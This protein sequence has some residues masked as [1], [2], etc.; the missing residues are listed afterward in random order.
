MGWRNITSPAHA[1]PGRAEGGG[2][3]R[4]GQAQNDAARRRAGREAGRTGRP[5]APGAGYGCGAAPASS[6]ATALGVSLNC[7]LKA[8]MK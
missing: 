3:A 2:R 7:F 8:E 1:G 4:A 6:R 5:G